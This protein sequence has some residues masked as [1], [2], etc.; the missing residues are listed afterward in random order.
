MSDTRT[1]HWVKTLE[2]QQRDGNRNSD[3]TFGN[4]HAME[5]AME[6]A[7]SV[8]RREGLIQLIYQHNTLSTHGWYLNLEYTTIFKDS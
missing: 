1:Q 6:K 3:A 8:V 2:Y 5:K 7:S 4:A